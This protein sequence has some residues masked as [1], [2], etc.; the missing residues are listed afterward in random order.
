MALKS[1]ATAERYIAFR[2]IFSGPSISTFATISALLRQ[3]AMS[4]RNQA[5]ISRHC[6]PDERRSEIDPGCMKT[7]TCNLRLEIP[8]R[9]RRCKRNLHWRLYWKKAIEKRILRALRS[10]E[11][12]TAWT[13]SGLS[14]FVRYANI[15]RLYSILTLANRITLPHFSVSSAMSFP[16]SPGGPASVVAPRSA[17]RACNFGSARP[18]FIT[19]LSFWW[20]PAL[21]SGNSSPIAI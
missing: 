1:N 17:R 15:E 11:F 9:F 19:P 12:H 3:S 6:V 10:G 13:Q 4:S 14:G 21:W 16:K 7:L 5:R 8:S 18:A 2:K 20:C